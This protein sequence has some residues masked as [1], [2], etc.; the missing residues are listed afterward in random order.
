[1]TYLESVII[2]KGELGGAALAARMMVAISPA[3]F[4]WSGPGSLIALFWWWSSP[5]H[6]LLPH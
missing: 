6:I 3:W 2:L 4:D 5:I 1:M